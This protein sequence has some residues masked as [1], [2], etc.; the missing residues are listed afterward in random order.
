MR[1]FKTVVIDYD[2]SLSGDRIELTYNLG[3]Q[4]NIE[5]MVIIFM[6]LKKIINYHLNDE[7]ELIWLKVN[8]QITWQ[9]LQI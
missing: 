9:E 2:D 4:W 3:K 1:K 7:G 5:I 8:W 6:C